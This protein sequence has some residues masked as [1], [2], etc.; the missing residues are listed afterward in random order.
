MFRTARKVA[1]PLMIAAAIGLSGTSAARA[2]YAHGAQHQFQQAM[3]PTKTA[4]RFRLGL[5]IFNATNGRLRLCVLNETDETAPVM[6]CSA[7]AGNGPKG[8][9]YLMQIRMQA[10]Y[11]AQARSGLWILNRQTGQARA[12]VV[13]N[14]DDPTTSL[15]CSKVQ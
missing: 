11:G 10:R 14:V 9:Y 3:L 8:R 4:G 6:K 5:W 2:Q 1:L 15:R 13:G 7:W 12:C